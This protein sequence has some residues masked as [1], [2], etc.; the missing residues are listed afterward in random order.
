MSLL[1]DLWVGRDA[2]LGLCPVSEPAGAAGLLSLA[3]T[4]TEQ[5]F[6]VGMAV[7]AAA[8]APGGVEALTWEAGRGWPPPQSFM[9]LCH[10]GAGTVLISAAVSAGG[11]VSL[12]FFTFSLFLV[13]TISFGGDKN[14]ELTF[15]SK[16]PTSCPLHVFV[17]VLHLL[18]SA[19]RISRNTG[20]CAG[21]WQTR[22]VH[23]IL[24]R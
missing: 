1:E 23:F 10:P 9:N 2:Q 16:L 7:C 12:R 11:M 4:T 13:L 18:P 15:T 24:L 5:A 17:S 21:L 22:F 14:E 20:Y 6:R 3:S 19:L 8:L